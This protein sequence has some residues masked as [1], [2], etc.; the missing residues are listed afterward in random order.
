LTEEDDLS[1]SSFIVHEFDIFI[2]QGG[3]T[4]D[5]DNVVG[6]DLIELVLETAE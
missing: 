6:I 3:C 4:D 5:N 1:N 2:R